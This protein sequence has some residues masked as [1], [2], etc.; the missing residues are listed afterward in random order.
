MTRTHPND[1]K[2]RHMDKIMVFTAVSE[3]VIF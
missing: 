2:S 3:F 1:E